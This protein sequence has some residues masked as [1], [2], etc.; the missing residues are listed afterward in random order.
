MIGG[1]LGTNDANAL[2]FNSTGEAFSAG[3]NTG[4]LYKVNVS[5]GRASVIG[6]MGGYSSAGDLVFYNDQLVLSGFKGCCSIGP[7]TPNY[8]VALN[9]KTGAVIG[10]PLLLSSHDVF[11]LVST[12]KNELFGL[13]VIGTT[14]TPALYHF[15][16]NNPVGHRDILLKNLQS[17][18]LG[19]IYGAAY[20]GNYQP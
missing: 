18:G 1:G 7:T 6:H 13:G 15:F 3:V 12:G 2:V 10:T 5:T 20:D 16:L 14:T 17:S 9:E 19:Q 8:I 11:G 4:E